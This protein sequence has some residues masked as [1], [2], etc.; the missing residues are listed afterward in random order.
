M[1]AVRSRDTAPELRLRQALHALGLRFRTHPPDIPGRPD[2]VNQSRKVA[3]FVDGDFW[4]GNPA[5]W[6][7]RGMTSMGELFPPEKRRFW[8]QKLE[9][10]MARDN[11]VNAMLSDSGWQVVRVWASEVLT[12]TDVVASRVA[13]VWR[14][15]ASEGSTQPRRR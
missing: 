5:A 11:E 7:Q 12:N 13:Q 14:S 9:R 8:T 10:N 4:H 6:R 15:Q 1:A 3:V 2:I